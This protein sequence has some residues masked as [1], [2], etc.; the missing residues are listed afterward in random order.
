MTDWRLARQSCVSIRLLTTLLW[1]M[2][3]EKLLKKDRL[4]KPQRHKD[5]K[6]SEFLCVLCVFVV[7]IILHQSSA[8]RPRPKCLSLAEEKAPPPLVKNR[9]N[10]HCFSPLIVV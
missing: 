2:C 10:S 4:I 1:K 3:S 9:R 7:F 6:D 5:H 8:R